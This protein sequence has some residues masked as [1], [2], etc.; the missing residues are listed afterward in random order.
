[1][2]DSG[3]KF[4][5][6]KELAAEVDN[7]K[8]TFQLHTVRII[9]GDGGLKLAVVCRDPFT[10]FGKEL[11]PGENLQF[12][13]TDI[14]SKRHYWCTGSYP[15]VPPFTFAAYGESAPRDDNLI[16]VYT[17]GA[18]INGESVIKSDAPVAAAS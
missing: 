1:L 6:G 14:F 7:E 11:S 2:A 13:V 18:F 8:R 9:N 3:P 12:S 16:T 10:Q 4:L 17:H 5:S 15:E